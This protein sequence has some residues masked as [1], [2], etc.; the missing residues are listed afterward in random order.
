MNHRS[1][2]FL[3]T[4]VSVFFSHHGLGGD[5]GQLRPNVLFIAV[6]DLND[7][8]LGLN[9]EGRAKTPNMDRLAKRGTLFTNA[10]CAAPACNP[11]RVSVLTGVAPSTSGVYINSQ[12]WRECS[13]LRDVSTLPLHFRDQGY[14]VLGGGKVYHAANLNVQ[15]LT[16]L[17]DP[18]PWHEF[19]PSKSR[20]L[21]DEHVPANQAVNGSNRFYRGRFDWDSLDVPDAEMGDAKVVTWAEKQLSIRHD[22]PLFL[23][24][25]IY[26]P[27][28]PWYTPKKWFDLYAESEIQLPDVPDDD[29]DDIPAAGHEMSKHEWHQW[30][31][32]HDKWDDAVQAYLASVS[33]ADAMVGRLLDALD[34]GSM[35]DNTIVVLWSD[36]GYHLGHK[37]HW[38]KRVLW[39]QATHVPLI[40]VDKRAASAAGRC[41]R[42]V[43]LLD[44][45]PTLVDLCG[46]KA[47]SHL[48][49]ESLRPFLRNPQAESTRAVVTTQRRNNH[50]V[51][52]QHWRYI[53]YADGS[54]ELYD[55]RN[56]RGEIH[57]LAA[58][59]SFADVK[60]R[61]AESLPAG[62]ATPDPEE[63]R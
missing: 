47:P 52:S 58:M 15:G 35:A 40:V 41:D 46:L 1:I 23:A 26:R 5:V 62:N 13:R 44:I 25:G 32:D 59:E 37:R 10:H 14:K 42:P 30:L 28:I 4:V 48:E 6:D 53:R 9:P 45:Y 55:H 33:F 56:D 2:R 38:E 34:K 57:N 18:K 51:R 50:S 8:A 29:G 49:G 60:R 19:F 63:R 36:H 7:Y 27:H 17:I 54:E 22:Q 61:L 11:S 31:V 12:D 21:A 20:Q 16:G 3:F 43:S 24:V 39:E